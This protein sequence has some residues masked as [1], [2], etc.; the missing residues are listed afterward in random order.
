[1]NIRELLN[2][3]MI[4]IGAE[5]STKDEALDKLIELQKDA[6]AVRNTVLLSREI[7]SREM[8]GSS[9]VSMR[10]AISSVRHSG[11]KKTSVS[12]LTVKDGI[13]YDSPDKRK[14]RLMFMISGKDGTDEDTDVKARIMHLLMDSEFTARLCAAKSKDE[15]LD[16][17]DEREK[18]RY[19]AIKPDKKYDCSRLIQNESKRSTKK[20]FFFSRN[21]SKN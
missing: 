15:F 8:L 4:E 18:V 17:I 21:K 7:R 13:S 9:A 14:V 10:A 2:E 16:I 12:A 20:L 5:L 6:G 1:M 11:A 19:P 3:N